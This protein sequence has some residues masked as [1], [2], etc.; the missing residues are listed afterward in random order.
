MNEPRGL[1]ARRVAGEWLCEPEDRWEPYPPDVILTGGPDR[2]YDDDPKPD[3]HRP[4]GFA[5]TRHP[6]TCICPTC[7]PEWHRELEKK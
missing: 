3:T 5:P 4:V 1:A 6:A 7:D 2:I